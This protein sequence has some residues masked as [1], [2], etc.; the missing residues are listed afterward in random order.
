MRKMPPSFFRSRMTWGRLVLRHHGFFVSAGYALFFGLKWIT[1]WQWGEYVSSKISCFRVYDQEQGKTRPWAQDL[2]VIAGCL[3]TVAC[4]VFAA[5]DGLNLIT[6]SIV[7]AVGVAHLLGIFIYHAN[8]LIFDEFRFKT[9]PRVW[10]FRR[11]LLQAVI[12]VAE[13]VF[14][15]AVLYRWALAWDAENPCAKGPVNL[16]LSEAFF[17]SVQGLTL[18]VPN[19]WA[20]K[21]CA[22]QEAVWVTQVAITLFFV[23][24]VLGQLTSAVFRRKE[25]SAKR[26]VRARR[27]LP[28]LPLDGS[29]RD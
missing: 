21:V 7:S 5:K 9:N 28:R 27:K 20:G 16:D 26:P 25:I 19:G 18:N 12:N 23:V 22:W 10:S 15:F 14:L 8:V 1:G 24:V 29:G 11:A 4:V 2:R 13:S 17:W 3:L 6:L